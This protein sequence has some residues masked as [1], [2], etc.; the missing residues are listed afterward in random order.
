MMN[1][2]NSDN[3]KWKLPLSSSSSSSSS[4]YNNNQTI[5]TRTQAS[6]LDLVDKYLS[7]KHQ[8]PPVNL[9]PNRPVRNNHLL[10]ENNNTKEEEETLSVKQLTSRF[11]GKA[12]CS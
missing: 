7:H 2:N 1:N 5:S 8:K 11:Q 3:K 6:Q 4:S 9:S 10:H 12:K